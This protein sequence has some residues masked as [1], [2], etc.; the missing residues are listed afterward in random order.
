MP[1]SSMGDLC[2]L[3]LSPLG[4]WFILLSKILN[5]FSNLST[6]TC[7]M[8]V[9]TETHCPLNLISTIVFKQISQMFVFWH[10]YQYITDSEEIRYGNQLRECPPLTLITATHLLYIEWMR[11]TSWLCCVVVW[12]NLY[13]L[14]KR[15]RR[16][17][18]TIILRVFC[19]LFFFCTRI[20]EIRIGLFFVFE[21]LFCFR[22]DECLFRLDEC[23]FR[24]DECLSFSDV[25]E[26]KSTQL[27]FKFAA[28]KYI[29]TVK[30][31]RDAE[32]N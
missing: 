12:Q 2:R 20:A 14:V 15:R 10:F 6:L 28:D 24:L 18:S 5:D 30:D 23:L 22:L 26:D 17:R 19:F 27:S 31:N 11:L 4:L 3:W 25:V 7:L 8:G 9:I 32:F 21:V 13:W 16:R 1:L 29:D